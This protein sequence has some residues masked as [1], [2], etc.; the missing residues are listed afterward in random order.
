MKNIPLLPEDLVSGFSL[1]PGTFSNVGKLLSDLTEAAC[2]L[3]T[4]Q[5]RVV[6]GHQVKRKLHPLFA[7]SFHLLSRFLEAKTFMLSWKGK[8]I[9]LIL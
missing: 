6:W 4:P 2:S 1:S 5:T 8:T 3:D 9:G 7:E